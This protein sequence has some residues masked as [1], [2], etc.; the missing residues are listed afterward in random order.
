[1]SHDARR[2]REAGGHRGA[3]HVNPVKGA[4]AAI[5]SS[6]RRKLKPP[7]VICH[8]KCFPTLCFPMTF[9]TRTPILSGSFSRPAAADFL[10]FSRSAS[11]A[12]SSFSRL[13]GAGYFQRR[14]TAAH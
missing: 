7:S 3:D 1:M 10:I 4:S 8:V 9:P 11:V 6:S 12:A 14:V 2:V 13:D 5:F